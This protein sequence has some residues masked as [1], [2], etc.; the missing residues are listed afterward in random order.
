MKKLTAFAAAV[1]LSAGFIAG[2]AL[3]KLGVSADANV[4][5]DNSGVELPIIPIGDDSESSSSI[6][7]SSSTAEI[8]GDDS[9][10]SGD[11]SSSKPDTENLAQKVNYTIT[12]SI[13]LIDGSEINT[14]IVLDVSDVQNGKKFS[15]TV[16]KE[17]IESILKAKGKTLED[18]EKF[19]FYVSTDYPDDQGLTD[20]YVVDGL[21]FEYSANPVYKEGIDGTYAASDSH[22]ASDLT[23]KGDRVLNFDTS[24][25]SKFTYDV[26]T[27]TEHSTN[28]VTF[29]EIT[30]FDLAVDLDTHNAVAHESNVE[31]KPKTLIGDLNGD[32]KVNVTDILKIAAHIKGKRLLPDPSAADFNKDGKINVTDI[33]KLAAHIKG[34]IRLS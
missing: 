33:I 34:K 17:E 31:P 24:E 14:N 1:V 21:S 23:V 2:A 12:A 11:D 26:T 3:P 19:V 18:F 32:N 9:L 20:K 10:E 15:K 7:D 16:T 27:G 5:S 30:G 13:K 29:N 8:G 25:L 4:S 28:N 6:D 22:D